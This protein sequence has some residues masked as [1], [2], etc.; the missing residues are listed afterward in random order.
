MSN[1]FVKII[2]ASALCVPLKAVHEKVFVKQLDGPDPIPEGSTA[3]GCP[4]AGPV[5]RVKQPAA[6]LE[7]VFVDGVVNVDLSAGLVACSSFLVAV[8][9]EKWGLA[10][11]GDGPHPTPGLGLAVFGCDGTIS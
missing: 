10:L 4:A 3:H 9:C 5:G 2:Q 8:V 1:F 6:P 7:H 11:N